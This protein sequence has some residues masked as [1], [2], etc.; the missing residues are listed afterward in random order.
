MEFGNRPFG[1]IVEQLSQLFRTAITL[2]GNRRSLLLVEL[3]TRKACFTEIETAEDSRS[4]MDPSGLVPLGE[5]GSQAR[6]NVAKASK[7]PVALCHG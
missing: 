2:S 7:T 1:Q 4:T 6:T 3:C 5:P